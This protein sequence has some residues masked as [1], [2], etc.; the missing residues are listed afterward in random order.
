MG[1][2]PNEKSPV[3]RRLAGRLHIN[4]QILIVEARYENYMQIE[5]EQFP[6]VA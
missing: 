5:M 6:L 3:E 1:A 2:P 4:S